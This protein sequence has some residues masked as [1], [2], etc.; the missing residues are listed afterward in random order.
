[1]AIY[2]RNLIIYVQND[3]MEKY[4]RHD[5]N[6]KD[7]KEV[8]NYESTIRWNY[9]PPLPTQKT[10]N[11]LTKFISIQELLLHLLFKVLESVRKSCQL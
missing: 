9:A 10:N 7:M 11:R 3:N 6:M 5:D 1:M 2:I 4:K 8:E